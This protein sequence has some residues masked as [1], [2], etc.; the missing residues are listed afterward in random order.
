MPFGE[1]PIIIGDVME[2]EFHRNK[3]LMEVES[4]WRWP[5]NRVNKQK[6]G[7]LASWR[8]NSVL[9]DNGEANNCW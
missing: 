8:S 7:P 1:Y 4:L 3:V 9:A 2:K 6:H 5:L